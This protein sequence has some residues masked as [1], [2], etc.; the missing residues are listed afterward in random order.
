[1]YSSQP[2]G[3]ELAVLFACPRRNRIQEAACHTRKGRCAKRVGGAGGRRRRELGA[4][5]GQ[6]RGRPSIS[7]VCY[8]RRDALRLPQ[9]KSAGIFW[10]ICSGHGKIRHQRAI[11]TYA[12]NEPP[13]LDAQKGCGD[14]SARVGVVASAQL[15]PPRPRRAQL[16]G[17]S[18]GALCRILHYCRPKSSG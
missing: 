7:C 1:V 2:E 3:P 13:V 10:A 6:H 8:L 9:E 15:L 16:M 11:A 5:E 4:L 12:T 17:A 18:G 14:P